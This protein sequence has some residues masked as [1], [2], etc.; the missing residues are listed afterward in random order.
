MR[1]LHHVPLKRKLIIITMFTTTLALALACVTFTIYDQ[2]ILRRD[3]VRDLSS[4][5]EMIG[6]NSSSALSFNDPVSAEQTLKSLAV[7]Q[8]ITGACVYGR[9]GAVFASYVR[10]GAEGVSFPT[11]V[12]DATAT[13]GRDRLVLARKIH[14]DGEVIGTVY[15]QSD[16]SELTERLK[17]STIIFAVVMLGAGL[18]GYVIASRLQRV[19]SEPVSHLA[20]KMG[21]VTADSNYSV[22]AI[23]R[24]NDEVGALID[25]FNGML[26]QIQTRDEKLQQAHDELEQRVAARTC[27]SP[28][29]RARL[30]GLAAQCHARCHHGWHHCGESRAQRGLLQQQIDRH[31][32]PAARD[33]RPERYC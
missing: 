4:T 7:H 11:S 5:A 22:R 32:G 14:F 8:N 3:L 26:T 23:K 29:T 2:V 27:C 21:Q 1:F 31:V 17:L 15:F 12:A 33:A 28:H 13:F 9:D 19:I 24:G 18:T 30:I 16:L 6:F 25:G 10:K 20:K